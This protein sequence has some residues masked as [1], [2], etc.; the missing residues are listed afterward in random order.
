MAVASA[1]PM[2]LLSPEQQ[3]REVMPNPPIENN[4]F[5]ILK[6]TIKVFVGKHVLNYTDIEAIQWAFSDN[7]DNP[8]TKIANI[9]LEF[10]NYGAQKGMEPYNQTIERLSNININ[11]FENL[12]LLCADLFPINP[13][14][15]G[16]AGTHVFTRSLL[17]SL[18]F[19]NSKFPIPYESA[20]FNNV[21]TEDLQGFMVDSFCMY[22]YTGSST[23]SPNERFP[24][25]PILLYKFINTVSRKNWPN[26]TFPI[27]RQELLNTAMHHPVPNV[28]PN[29]IL[30]SNL[31]NI[32][33]G[34]QI[35]PEVLLETEPDPKTWGFN[36]HLRGQN[37]GEC[38][39][40]T[41]RVY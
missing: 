32:H 26:N 7:Y 39:K 18:R 35:M 24:D 38:L 14:V 2:H 13:T 34:S 31:R 6:I 5:N 8:F 25:M 16:M 12:H 37:R 22:I 4:V 10:I 15:N 29:N 17:S 33:N 30:M 40:F 3:M 19:V 41:F 11:I 23:L 36:T 9:I 27:Y 20:D 28:E 21:D 1:P